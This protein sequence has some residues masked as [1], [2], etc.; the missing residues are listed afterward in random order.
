MKKSIFEIIKRRSLPVMTAYQKDLLVHDKKDIENH[1]GIPFVHYTGTTGTTTIFFADKSNYPPKGEKVRYIF[2]LSDRT[3][4][5]KDSTI[6]LLKALPRNNRTEM[7]QYFDG[8]KVHKVTFEQ[9]AWIVR[10]YY[11]DMMKQFKKG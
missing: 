9:S 3:H 8:C 5:L 10:L 2:G 1:A 7:I 4:I 11:I 6:G